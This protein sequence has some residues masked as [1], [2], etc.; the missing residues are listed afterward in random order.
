MR[1]LLLILALF[2]PAWLFAGDLIIH[3]NNGAQV[4]VPM[5]DIQ[6]ITFTASKLETLTQWMCGSFS[7]QAQADTSNDPYHADVRLKMRRI[8]PE[9]TDGYWLYVEQAYQESQSTPYRQRVY[10]V[11]EENN[12]IKDLIYSLPNAASY[13]GAW[14]NPELLNNISP[15]Q[16]TLKPNCGLFFNDLGDHFAGATQGTGC[17]ATI[18]GVSY[19]TSESSIYPTYLTSW[20]LGYNSQGV[21]VMG[22]YSPYKFDKLETFPIK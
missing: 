3:K 4:I 15:A 9:R 21:C 14:N 7:S 1:K 5:A 13:V 10:R 19:L 6:K 8:W 17:T 18:P 12:Q 2:I 20:D 11:I 16:L 22:P